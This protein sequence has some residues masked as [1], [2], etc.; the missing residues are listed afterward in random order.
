MSR[1]VSVVTG[2]EQCRHS[3]SPGCTRSMPHIR[4]MPSVQRLAY[5]AG[6]EGW[7]DRKTAAQ[8]DAGSGMRPPIRGGQYKA[9]ES[10]ESHCRVPLP[11]SRPPPF[12]SITGRT[13]ASSN[14]RSGAGHLRLP[15]TER[16]DRGMTAG[17]AGATLGA[18]SNCSKLLS[19][20]D[21]N[22]A[23]RCR[24]GRWPQPGRMRGERRQHGTWHCPGHT[25]WRDTTP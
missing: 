1:S 25:T 4:N 20:V 19:R 9:G 14:G 24:Q 23:G 3:P 6:N 10:G 2:A 15:G 16:A 13:A 7:H 17:P 18:G 8:R 5:L 12:L 22:L 11:P 21:Q